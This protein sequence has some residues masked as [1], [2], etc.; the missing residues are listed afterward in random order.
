MRRAASVVFLLFA[1]TSL[2]ALVAFGQAQEIGVPQDHVSWSSSVQ[3]EIVRPGG[4]VHAFFDAEIGEAWKMYALDSSLPSTESVLS[5]PYGVAFD[6]T[7]L[8][9]GVTYAGETV[10]SSPEE[11]YDDIFGMTLKYFHEGARFAAVFDVSPDAPEGSQT[12]E[13]GVRYQICNDDIG[14][15][16]NRVTVPVS[17]TFAVDASCSGD[18]CTADPAA[19]AA[20][21]EGSGRE[22]DV[23]GDFL[24]SAASDLATSRSGGFWAFLLLAVGAGLAS[25]LTPCVFPMIPLTVSYFTKHADNRP[26]AFRLASVFGGSIV[27]TFTGVGVLAAIVVGAAGAQRIASNPWVNLFI[28]VVLVGFALALLGL[29]ELRLPT[30][31]LNYFNRQ[32]NE[33]SGIVGVLFMGL[34]LTLVSFSCTAPFVG[35]LLAAAS[36]GT[37]AYP[38][39]GMVAYSATFALPFV[40]L[41]MFPNALNA[42]PR[43]GSWMNVLKVVLGFVELAAAIKFFSN[44]DL[45]WGWGLISRPL[46]IAFVVVVF[47]LAGFYL[48][49]RLRL[50]HEPPIESI[51]VGRMLGAVLFFVAALYMLPGLLG[52]PLNRLDA[53]LPPRQ[54]TDVSILSLFPSAGAGA[55]ASND[56]GWIV[57]DVDEAFVEGIRLKQPVFIDFS[58]YTCTNCREMEANVF[59]RP[60]VASRLEDFVR[61]RLYT[62]GLERGDDLSRFQLQLT[63]TV[64]LPT[65]AVVDPASRKVLAK[66]SGMM[67][68]EA[69]T[70]FLATGASV[71]G[72]QSKP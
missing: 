69:F 52:A 39:L 48:L 8:P 5:R 47:T 50:A 25:L 68:V 36:G 61:L 17:V 10:Q 1:V 45:L 72:L 38:L 58:G 63:G 54:G 33:K 30:G 20:L 3:P 26:Q 46:G 59:P 22:T 37:W 35:G 23:P 19:L 12:I 42:L 34:T 56:E 21:T 67:D 6:W 31:L 29:Y 40:L 53:Y 9:D 62:D 60:A 2:N 27:V 51:G 16:L 70:Q 32:G 66:W 18:A 41:A 14:I 13:A 11:K 57:D 43:S 65:Y 44:A 4:R 15:C 28:A 71:H 24:L 64:A 7:S 55:S 49:G